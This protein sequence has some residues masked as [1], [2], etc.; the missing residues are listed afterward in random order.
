MLVLDSDDDWSAP[1]HFDAL[2]DTV[3]KYDGHI[4]VYLMLNPS[5]RTIATPH[6]VAAWR[7]R[8]HS[9]GI[10]HNPYDEVYG[11]ADEE[12]LLERVVRAEL[13]DFVETYGEVPRANRNH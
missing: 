11:G 8:G 10:H 3:E 7:E 4:T 13:A 5:K 12:E 9:F 6:Q 1:E 2:I